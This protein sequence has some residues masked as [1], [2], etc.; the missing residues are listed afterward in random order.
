MAHNGNVPPAGVWV[1]VFYEGKKDAIGEV[2]E[3]KP[4]LDNDNVHALKM[5]VKENYSNKL[6]QFSGSTSFSFRR[7]GNLY[8]FIWVCLQRTEQQRNILHH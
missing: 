5:K 1:L 7:K 6:K 3:I 4:I 2:S 8:G